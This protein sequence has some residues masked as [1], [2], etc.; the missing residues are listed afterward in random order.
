MHEIFELLGEVIGAVA[1]WL[2]QL[3]KKL[4][5]EQNAIHDLSTFRN[6]KKNQKSLKNGTQ[7]ESTY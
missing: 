3:D 5:S 6:T 1:A 7:L 4:Y 2:S